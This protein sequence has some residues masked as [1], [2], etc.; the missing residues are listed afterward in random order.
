MHCSLLRTS[1][2]TSWLKYVTQLC[3]Y[4]HSAKLDQ[5]L[6]PVMIIRL[7]EYNFTQTFRHLHVRFRLAMI[8]S[9]WPKCS[10]SH[11][12]QVITRTSFNKFGI[13]VQCAGIHQ[14][15]VLC[16]QLL[17]RPVQFKFKMEFEGRLS[18]QCPAKP[19]DSLYSLH[20]VRFRLR[21]NEARDRTGSG[22]LTRYPTRSSR[23]ALWNKSS[24]T[25]W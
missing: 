23:S 9:T 1:T 17:P 24:T 7:T 20:Y 10:N 5:H 2:P 14:A 12:A 22:F 6:L 18:T 16:I 15:M 25:A 3:Q 19:Y 8:F 21:V 13:W 4:R 11:V